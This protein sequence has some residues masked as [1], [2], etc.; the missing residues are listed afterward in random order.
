MSELPDGGDRR[1]VLRQPCPTSSCR[2]LEH[3]DWKTNL[4]DVSP[5]GIGLICDGPMQLGETL[6]LQLSGP[7]SRIGLALLARIVH[8]EEMGDG[9]WRVGCAFDFC[10][11]DVLVTML[12]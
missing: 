1:A 5:L 2:L 9:Q 10:L 4:L 3:G 11:P 7:V 12:L 6:S 8:L